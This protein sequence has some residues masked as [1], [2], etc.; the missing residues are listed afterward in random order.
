M[1]IYPNNPNLAQGTNTTAVNTTNW[2][3]LVDN[4]NTIGADLVD[5]RG[6][7]QAFPGTPH[8][9]GQCGDANDILQAIKHILADVSGETNWYNAPSGSL[10]LHNHTSGQGGLIPWN[11]LGT[12]VSRK[13][14]LHPQYCGALLTKSLRGASPS[15]NNIITITNDVDVVSYVGRH[16]YDGVSAQASLQ[17]YYVAVRF[18]LPVDFG[19]WASSNAIQIEHRTGS[20]LSSDCHVD[21]YVY[22]SGSGSVVASSVNNVNVNWSTISISGSALGTWAA[23]DILEMYIKLESRNNNYA[24]IGKMALNYNS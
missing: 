11:S 14:E 17:D 1:A 13:I 7:G 21:A 24:R 20:A 18:T 22:K 15:G 10:K 9:A 12:S 2:N 23:N 3:I 8:A 16:Y 6:D 19:S 4:I 5:A